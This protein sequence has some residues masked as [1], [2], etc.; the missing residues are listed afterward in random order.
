LHENIFSV[1]FSK[2][3]GAIQVTLMMTLQVSVRVVVAKPMLHFV[4]ALDSQTIA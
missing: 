1:G 3:I 2:R 4:K